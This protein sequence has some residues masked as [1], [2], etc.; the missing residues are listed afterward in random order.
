[1]TLSCQ[2]MSNPQ[3]TISERDR[4][5]GNYVC[6]YLFVSI[7]NTSVKTA[8]PLGDNAGRALSVMF[9]LVLLFKSIKIADYIL[10]NDVRQLILLESIFIVLYSLTFLRGTSDVT[11]LVNRVF[12]TLLICIPMAAII[13]SISN[14]GVLYDCLLKYSYFVIILLFFDARSIG[15]SYDASYSMSIS[16]AILPFVL[17]QF[18][19]ASIKK[20]NLIFAIAY[21]V[22]EIVFAARGAVLCLCFFAAVQMLKRIRRVRYFF[23]ILLCGFLIIIY[24]DNILAFI[25]ILLRERGLYSYNLMHLINGNFLESKS[26]ADLLRYYISIA[27][28]RPLLGW[29]LFGGWIADGLGPHNGIL[30]CYVQFGYVIGSILALLVLWWF[31]RAIW[32]FDPKHVDTVVVLIFAASCFSMLISAGE[33]FAKPTF[34]I[35]GELVIRYGLKARPFADNNNLFSKY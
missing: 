34:F 31:V 29:G 3:D 14:L 1:M 17:V 18:F 7:L 22:Y 24:Y 5:L 12:T 21:A 15:R 35:F 32:L 20:V 4:A 16:Y 11:I 6:L 2:A 8:F 23:L 25:S 27:K 10:R 26:R 28:Q 19:Q 30:E 33:I 13:K 9:F